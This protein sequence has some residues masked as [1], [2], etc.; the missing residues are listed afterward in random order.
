[1]ST[2]TFG[3]TPGFGEKVH[4]TLGYSQAVRVGDRVEISGQAG[5]DDDLVV[6]EALEDEI[7]LAFD[8]VERTLATVGA[9]WKDVIHVNSY[10]KVAPGDDAIDDHNAVMTEQFRRRLGG[11][12]P[13]WTETGVTVL[14]LA[15]M[16]VEIRVTAVVGSGS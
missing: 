15:A 6:P 10:H 2:V 14:G 16:R 11:R 4:Q 8:N 7:V 12:A 1:M 13:I 3:I 5:V 9:T